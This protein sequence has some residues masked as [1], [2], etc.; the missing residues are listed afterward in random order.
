MAETNQLMV[1]NREL[2]EILIKRA[3]V[4]EGLWT[5]LVMFTMTAGN[6][7]QSPNE[8]NP[9]VIASLE[10][11]GIQRVRPGAPLNNLTVDAAKVNPKP[12]GRSKRS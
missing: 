1:Q 3:G 7:G 5:L 11:V 12:R 8:V 9:S 6:V 4:H 10:R 2:I